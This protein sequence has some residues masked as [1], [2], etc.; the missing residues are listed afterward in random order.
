[1]A[2]QHIINN[3]M[4]GGIGLFPFE[5]LSMMGHAEFVLASIVGSSGKSRRMVNESNEVE[6]SSRTM[7]KDKYSGCSNHFSTQHK[8]EEFVD[9]HSG[10]LGL[11]DEVKYTSTH[12]VVDKVVDYTTE[13]K[14]QVKFKKTVYPQQNYPKVQQV[15]FK[16]TVYPNK[17][18]QKCNNNKR[19]TK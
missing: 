3:Y 19:N 13:Y 8:A 9:K 5:N 7:Y 1:M 14:T 15:K 18:A 2:D 12:K 16:K 17:T 4:I 10:R 11:K 6:R